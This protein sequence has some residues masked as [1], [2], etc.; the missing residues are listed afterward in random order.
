M[1]NKKTGRKSGIGLAFPEYSGNK[2]FL[3]TKLRLFA[4]DEQSLEQMPGE[5]WFNRLSDY[6]HVSRI[7]PVPEKPARYARF[8]HVKLKG[9]WEKLA[10]RRAKRK[11]ETFEQALAHFE[12]F[13]EQRSNLPYINMHSETNG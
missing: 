11:G 9:N 1:E 8:K 3:G 10:R 12:D 7:R 13:E 2:F 5:K 4:E 6:M